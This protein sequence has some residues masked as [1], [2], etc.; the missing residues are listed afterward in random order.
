[1]LLLVVLV[2]TLSLL[3]LSTYVGVGAAVGAE[4]AAAAALQVETG[5]AA[6]VSQLKSRGVR[7][8]VVDCDLTLLDCHTAGR[9]EGTPQQLAD[10]VVYLTA[11]V[12]THSVLCCYADNL[13][14]F[15]LLLPT[16]MLLSSVMLCSVLLPAAHAALLFF[17]SAAC[18][19]PLCCLLQHTYDGI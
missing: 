12:L 5:T 10:K 7:L 16:G 9:W 3:L 6:L 8:V 1:M 11:A 18:P 2:N 15:L 13:C 17:L 4:Y 19:A 14:M